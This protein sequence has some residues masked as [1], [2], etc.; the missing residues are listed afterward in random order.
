MPDESS[1]GPARHEPT[2]VSSRV[3]WIGMPA[4]VIS[5]AALTVLVLW[6]FP[7][8]T[9]DRTM[10]LPLPR[11]P[12]PELQVSPR[13]AMATFHAKEMPWLNG[14]GWVDK[15]QGVVHVPIEEAMRKVAQEG[16]PGW[17]SG[18]GTHDAQT[19][20]ESPPARR[21]AQP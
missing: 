17:P 5:V 12:S 13:N 4:L 20:D 19:H 14:T 15:A 11:Y 2:D 16:I 21:V 6:L 9:V 8:R 18:Q 7:G 1:L 10:H 3:I